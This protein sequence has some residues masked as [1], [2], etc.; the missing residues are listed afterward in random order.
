VLQFRILG[1]LEVSDG[2]DALPLHGPKERALLAYLLLHANEVVPTDRIIDDIWGDEPPRTV[3]SVLHVYVSRLRKVLN[4]NNGAGTGLFREQTGYVLRIEDEQLDLHRFESLAHA[5][6]ELLSTGN[7]QGA[8]RDLRAALSL[9]RGAP[10]P[11]LAYEPWAEIEI[12]RLNEA[13]LTALEDRIDADLA[14]GRQSNVIAELEKLVADQPLRERT[15]A[16]LMLALYR[17]GRQADALHQ[18]DEARRLLAEELG[19]EPGP[20]LKRLHQGILTQEPWLELE[21]SEPVAAPRRRRFRL[22]QIA[23]VGILLI[24]G[25]IVAAAFVGRSH[26]SPQA[27]HAV[28]PNSV[29]VID[30]K[31]NRIVDSIP[32]GG[33][34]SGIASGAG[35][36]WVGNSDGQTLLRIDPSTGKT[37]ESIALPSKPTDVAYGPRDVWVSSAAARLLLRIDPRYGTIDRRIHLHQAAYNQGTGPYFA[38]LGVGPHGVWIGHDV[39]ALTRIDPDRGTPV[40]QLTLDAPPVFIADGADRAWVVTTGLGYLAAVNPITNSVESR[41]PLPGWGGGVAVG[42]D[43]VWVASWST[44]VVWRIDPD[45]RK[46]TAIIRVGRGPLNVAV[47]AGGVWVANTLAGT[48]SRID[49]RTNRVVKTI[50]LGSKPGAL[51]VAGDRLFVAVS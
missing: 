20:T 24:A 17:S 2:S 3:G 26:P 13:R 21:R 37:V 40:T 19:L 9:W 39:S 31:T 7:P 28:P 18:Y 14:L 45:T 10:L 50:H 32:I 1:S 44:N 35:S 34:V 11:E 15:R 49:P 23:V 33:R 30:T 51:T 25:A 38:P 5:G 27:L 46:P 8:A 16:Q 41:T 4:E 6:K 22:W 29:G 43:A 12:A 48:V 47:G 36:I 42:G